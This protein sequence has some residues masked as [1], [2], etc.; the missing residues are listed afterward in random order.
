MDGGASLETMPFMRPTAEKLATVGPNA[1][2]RTIEGQGHD[3]SSRV[4][5]PVLVEFFSKKNK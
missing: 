4:L 2:R 3:V 1:Q 5:A